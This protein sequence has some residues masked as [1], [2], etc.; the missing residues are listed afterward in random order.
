MLI[1]EMCSDAELLQGEEPASAVSKANVHVGFNPIYE[2][3]A[4][5]DTERVA[6]A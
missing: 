4:L 1:A 6:A 2:Y 3:A 5:P